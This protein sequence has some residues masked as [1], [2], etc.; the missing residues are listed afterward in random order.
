MIT[1]KKLILLAF[2]TLLVVGCG[3]AIDKLD[4]NNEDKYKVVSKRE[5][6][7]HYIYRLLKIGNTWYSY[8][9]DYR[10]TTNFEVGDTLIIS[11]KKVDD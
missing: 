9:Y 10:D 11:I 6:D 7:S 3:M 2:T 8:S 1:I 4:V 5:E